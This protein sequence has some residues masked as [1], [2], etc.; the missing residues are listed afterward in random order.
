MDVVL[1]LT[2]TFIADYAYRFTHPIKPAPYDYPHSAANA[3]AQTFSAWTY[4][5]ATQFLQIQPSQ[6]AYMSAWPRDNVWRQLITLYFITWYVE[7]PPPPRT[8]AASSS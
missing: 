8:P 6:S 7:A 2:D 3:T 4:K 1:E 5:P